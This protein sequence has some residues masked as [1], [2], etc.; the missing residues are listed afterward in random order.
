MLANV[1]FKDGR[2]YAGETAGSVIE[3]IMT[4]A[5]IEDYTVEEEVAQTPLYGTLKIQTCQKALRE[6]LFACAAIMNTSRRSGIE[7]RKSTRRIST[8]IPRSRKFSTTLKADT[9]VSDAV[10]T[11]LCPVIVTSA[12]AFPAISSTT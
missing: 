7:I 3:E 11:Y 8:T 12:R 1:D 6:V 4:A 5:G 10:P 2:I 9:Y